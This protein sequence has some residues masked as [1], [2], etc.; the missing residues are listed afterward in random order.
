M[1]VVALETSVRP[2]SIAVHAD[3]ETTAVRLAA[4][5][6]HASDLLPQL[7]ELLSRRGARARDVRAVFVGTGPGSYTGL[8][9]G[10]ATALGLARGTGAELFGVPSV[11]ALAFA[12]LAP[13]E[14]GSVL[15]DARANALYL[16][17]YERRERDVRA[18]VEP[19]AISVEELADLLPAEGPIFAD[20]TVAE[21]ARLDD[22]QRARL[23]VGRAP[24]AA[25]ALELGL[26]WLARHGPMHPE[27][28]EPLY[29]RAFSGRRRS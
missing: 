8:R 16:A 3:G 26:E 28:V 14:I 23:I 6:R 4:E 18:I 25:A 29:L 17:S 24:H 9:V 2:P 13:G 22:D 1:T 7:E 11:A 10:I 19:T 5:R 12:E 21:V 27:E 15:L 20:P